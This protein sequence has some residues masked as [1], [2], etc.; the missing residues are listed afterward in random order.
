MHHDGLNE[1]LQMKIP[2]N[3]LCYL[4]HM[5]YSVYDKYEMLRHHLIDFTMKVPLYLI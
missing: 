4:K 1:N 3:R 2:S 5:K